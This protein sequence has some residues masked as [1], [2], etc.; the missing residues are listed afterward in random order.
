MICAALLAALFT[1]RSFAAPAVQEPGYLYRATLVQA[2][3]GKLLELIELYKAER[4]AMPARGDEP[5]F[6]MRHSQ[7]D[8]WDLLLLFP[9]GSYSGY[10]GRERVEARQKAAK[11]AAETDRKMRD[12][13]FRRE[14]VFVWGPPLEE[15]RGRFEKAAFFHVEMFQ[16]LAGRQGDLAKEREM[17]SAYLKAIGRPTNLLFVRD[18]GADWDLF[19]IGFY[20]DLKHYAESADIP[21]PAQESAAKAAGFE[22]AKA[23]GPYLRTLISS[24][25]DTLAVAVK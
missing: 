13:I 1:F 2:A 14:D 12:M 20:R 18:A 4:A 24:H 6:W 25:H 3:P 19:T 15:V 7:G 22:S 11:A 8:H 5:F 9:M 23:I 10:F 16:S 17:E 21:E